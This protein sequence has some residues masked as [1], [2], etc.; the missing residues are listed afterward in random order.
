MCTHTRTHTLYD[1]LLYYIYILY[2]RT[3]AH[4]YTLLLIPTKCVSSEELLLRT[5]RRGYRDGQLGVRIY[6]AT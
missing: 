5:V 2:L 4:Y 6:M 1:V 3:S